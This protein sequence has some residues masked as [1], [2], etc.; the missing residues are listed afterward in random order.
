MKLSDCME[1]IKKIYFGDDERDGLNKFAFYVLQEIK[2][3]YFYGKDYPRSG[4]LMCFENDN[5]AFIHKDAYIPVENLILK[6]KAT[7][8]RP[9]LYSFQ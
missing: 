1:Q 6:A 7:N 4:W 3:N 8:S 2:Y 5:L 9:Y